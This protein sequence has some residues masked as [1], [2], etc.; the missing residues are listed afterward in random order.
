MENEELIRHQMENTRASITEKLETL[1]NKVTG[2]IQGATGAV[3]DT[4]TAVTDSVK[5]TVNT[6]KES[7]EGTAEAVKEAVH[8]SMQTVKGWF[9]ITEQVEAHPWVF[10]A[11]SVAVGFYLESLARA[12]IRS[13]ENASRG[14][15]AAPISDNVQAGS[16]GASKARRPGVHQRIALG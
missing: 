11:G 9:N 16:N 14:I 4:V 3:A 5:E 7:V 12:S 2:D 6:V 10:F 8:D 15:V 13:V 1:E